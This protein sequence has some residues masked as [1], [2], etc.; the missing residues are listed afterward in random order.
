M[1]TTRR[2]T[3]THFINSSFVWRTAVLILLVI[4]MLLM[5][6][7]SSSAAPAGSPGGGKASL[8]LKATPTKKGTQSGADREPGTTREDDKGIS[9]VW[10]PAG[11]FPMG[12]DTS[13]DVP[14]YNDELPQ[15]EVCFENGFW[16]DQYEITN[17]AFRA[18]I[19]DDGYKTKDY[20]TKEG[21]SWVK[22]NGISQ[23]RDT[24]GFTD[25]KL[26]RTGITWYEAQ[27]YATWRGGRLPTEAEWEYAA[28][29]PN[30]YIFP[31]GDDF[32][33][34]ASNAENKIQHTTEVGGYEDGK[35]WV[36]AYDMAGNVWEWVNDWYDGTYYK[37]QVRNDPKGPSTGRY[38]VLRGG[39]WYS[40]FRLVRTATRYDVIPASRFTIIGARI[41]TPDDGS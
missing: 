41:M 28:R 7:A 11:C 18:F 13:K 35:S 33:T 30:G 1:I 32:D 8:S 20:W 6:S 34:E 27:A 17:E 12:T 36:N 24:E 15:H 38:R 29:G 39:S 37:L 25:D 16:M 5:G 21:W 19:D 31:W 22:N 40:G 3:P 10:V 2:S 4:A 23:P 26:P 14:V 9:Q